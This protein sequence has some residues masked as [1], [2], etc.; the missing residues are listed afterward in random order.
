ME[1]ITFFRQI[2]FISRS[3]CR[4][5]SEQLRFGPDCLRIHLHFT[6]RASERSTLDSWQTFDFQGLLCSFSDFSAWFCCSFF[7]S[8]VTSSTETDKNDPTVH[9]RM[10]IPML[11]LY[12]ILC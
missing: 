7:Q 6:L 12:P 9:A 1:R 8:I 5:S 3:N 10:Y 2:L 11:E 4:T